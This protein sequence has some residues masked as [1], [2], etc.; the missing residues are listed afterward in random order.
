[1]KSAKI[2]EGMR[3]KV[4]VLFLRTE[5][6]TLYLFFYMTVLAAAARVNGALPARFVDI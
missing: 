1:M 5:L 2:I 4:E 3:K 6:D